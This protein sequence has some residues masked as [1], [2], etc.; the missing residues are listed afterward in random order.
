[1]PMR[2]ATS[3]ASK[4]GGSFTYAFFTFFGQLRVFT[5]ATLM[6][7]K[8]WTAALIDGLFARRSTM[9]TNV[10]LSSIFFMAASVVTGF[11]IIRNASS[12]EQW[13]QWK[14]TYLFLLGMRNRWSFGHRGGLYV[15]GRLNLG[16][17]I[18]RFLLLVWEPK[19]IALWAF[20][21]F[22][23]FSASETEPKAGIN[24][25][26]SKDHVLLVNC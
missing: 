26:L 25:F 8:D 16:V 17:F 2:F 9:K 3:R 23:T 11:W 12:L 14:T 22:C 6:L 4:S 7:Y 21:A 15:L 5:L 19:A 1:M 10:S 18:I 20:N 24:S 13:T